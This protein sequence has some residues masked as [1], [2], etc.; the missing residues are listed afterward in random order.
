MDI[1]LVLYRVYEIFTIV[2]C[3]MHDAVEAQNTFFPCICISQKPLT[4]INRLIFRPL[5]SYCF[6]DDVI[7]LT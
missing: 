7:Q 5:H 4:C 2:C 3:I 6:P 1:D